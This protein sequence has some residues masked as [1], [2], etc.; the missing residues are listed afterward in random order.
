MNLPIKTNYLGNILFFYLQRIINT[1]TLS[2]KLKQLRM[3]KIYKF[4]FAAVALMGA[5]S[6]NAQCPGGQVNVTVD[7]ATDNWGYECFWDV[8]PTGNGCGTG[9]L[10]TFGNPTVGCA[11]GGAQVAVGTDPGAYANNSTITETLGC[12][13]IGDCFDINYVDDW[14]DGGATFTVYFDGIA[15]QTFTGAGAGGVFNFCASLA[16]VNDVNMV[17]SPYEYTRVPLSQ[18]GN[19]VGGGTINSLGS[20]NVTGANMSVNVLQGAT[21]VYSATST[22]QN[23]NSGASANFTVAGFTPTAVG[24]YQVVYTSDITETDEDLTNNVISYTVEVTDSIYAR[25]NNVKLGTLGIGAGELGYLG[26]SFTI[27][28]PTTLTSAS[29][30]ID[31][32]DGLLTG[33]TYSIDVFG[34]DGTGTP[35]GAVLATATGTVGATADQ[36]YTATFPSALNLGAGKYVVTLREETTATQQIGTSA[37][38]LTPNTAWVSWASQPWA[39]TESFGPGFTLTF[40]IRANV[41][42]GATV[43]ELTETALNVYPN[44]VQSELN[45][46]NIEAGS[47]VE[48]YNNVGQ[49]VLSTVA[50]TEVIT[51][52]V[53]NFESGIYTVK[54]VNGS[55]VG[56]SKFVKK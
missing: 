17:V 53:A 23:I 46:S 35:T 51:L 10:F 41:N 43:N 6:A 27:V 11:G 34:T 5:S 52:N 8:T 14:G 55:T 37:S 3:K 40:M 12:L 32:G 30:F 24:T 16:A 45:V 20:G 36:W 13:T 18:V 19:I 38:V 9:S 50:N 4:A 28:N 56:V 49:L 1:L 29:V 7:V 33:T 15:D 48:V 25:D 26:N 22:T 47:A 31:N 2:L 42:S 39:A 44:P 21:S 54:A